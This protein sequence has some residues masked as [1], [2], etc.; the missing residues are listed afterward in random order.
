MSKLLQAFTVALAVA[1]I[2]AAFF[3]GWLV[4]AS[5]NVPTFLSIVHA[6]AW[7]GVAMAALLIVRKPLGTF[8]DRR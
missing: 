8:I 7:P 2:A 6:I 1:M 5:T 4:G 3:L